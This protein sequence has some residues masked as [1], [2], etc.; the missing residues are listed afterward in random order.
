[1]NHPARLAVPHHSDLAG[2]V[3]ATSHSSP[4][5]TSRYTTRERCHTCCKDRNHSDGRCPQPLAPS[6]SDRCTARRNPATTA[7]ARLPM[8]TNILL[9]HPEHLAPTPPQ[10]ANEIF[11]PF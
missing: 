7:E 8:E 11:L 2:C 6:S 1:M 10:S 4:P 9:G 3:P 5:H